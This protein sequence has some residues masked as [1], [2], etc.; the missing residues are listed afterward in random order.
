[1]LPGMLLPPRGLFYPNFARPIVR[2][3]WD[4]F[5]VRPVGSSLPCPWC[6]CTVPVVLALGVSPRFVRG[7]LGAAHGC[8]VVRIHAH[9]LKLVLL[10]PEISVCS[11]CQDGGRGGHI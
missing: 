2:G 4:S 1:M 7:A 8:L 10:A 9:A 11:Q 3:G 5:L 6:G